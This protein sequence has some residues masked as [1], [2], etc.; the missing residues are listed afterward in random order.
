MT[1]KLHSQVVEGSRHAIHNLTYPNA[2]NRIAGTGEGSGINPPTS[3][4]LWQVAKQDD[5]NTLWLLVDVAP[6]TWEQI[7]TS[8]S[9]GFL[10]DMDESYD[11]FGA[12]PS[13]IVVD[14]AQGQGTSLKWDLNSASADRFFEVS[15]V[16]GKDADGGDGLVYHNGFKIENGDDGFRAYRVATNLM[17]IVGNLND[18]LLQASAG[19][20]FSTVESGL[21]LI[22]NN[23][24]SRFYRIGSKAGPSTAALNSSSGIQSFVDINA[25]VNQSGTASYN[26]L[27]VNVSVNA[28]GSGFKNIFHAQYGGT[29]RFRVDKV[30][31]IHGLSS[32]NDGSTDLI[33][34]ADS[35]ALTQFV[36]N[37]DGNVRI[38]T[39]TP[40]TATGAGDLYV[41]DAL[42]VDGN[43]HLGGNI[44]Q[45]LAF[46]GGYGITSGTVSQ[47]GAI[48]PVNSNETPPTWYWGTG[49]VSNHIVIGEY[50]DRTYDFAHALATNPTLFIHSAN[51]S[52][53]E[54][55]SAAHDQ[56]NGV[57]A[58][59]A[60]GLSLAPASG[61]VIYPDAGK[62]VYDITPSSDLTA[63]GDIS[64]STVDAN[65]TGVG[66]ALYQA[67]DGN[68]EEADADA[69]ATMPCRALAL[70]TGTGTKKI[71]RRGWIRKDAWSWTPG[72]P[73]YVDT[74]T[75]GLTQT[76]PSG[77]GDQV[78]IVGYAET[79]DILDFNPST[80]IVEVA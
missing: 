7:M 70:E 79:A 75:G 80:V 2:A 53:A 50:A 71:L 56:T 32:T 78:Q 22:G 65:A 45:M 42:E 77:T 36:V 25:N 48:I 33:N 10:T 52:T 11:N 14:A 4:N 51:Q 26:A 68:W 15:L 1:N 47:T 20:E 66:A 60:G 73:V 43:F 59:G 62:T 16:N 28:E 31:T 12:N 19:I 3:T 57:L 37:S 63:T 49:T 6:L 38:G 67:S 23:D 5:D 61:E 46:G 13:T 69:L 72:A 40:G 24:T 27:S 30:G 55:I 44:P 41:T 58:T 74:T 17:N 9:P 29:T 8:A 54:W 34:L 64:S 76:K 18:I 21:L 39:G 35:G